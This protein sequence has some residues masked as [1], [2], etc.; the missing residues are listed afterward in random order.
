MSVLN[1]KKICKLGTSKAKGFKGCGKLEYLEWGLCFTC[2]KDFLLNTAEGQELIIKASKKAGMYSAKKSRL[3]TKERKWELKSY[4]QKVNEV[5]KVFQKWIRERDK[6]KPCIS[7]GTP[8]SEVWHA[9]HYMKAELYSGVVFDENNVFRQCLKCNHYLGGNEAQYRIALCLLL[10][11]S[12]VVELENK[13]KTM[14][15]YK[16]SDTELIEIKNKY[17]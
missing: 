11:E 17:K 2:K 3:E 15:M 13:A 8:Y 5:R 9:G 14:R 7:C 16:Y 6:D 12:K 4:S 1:K 10:G